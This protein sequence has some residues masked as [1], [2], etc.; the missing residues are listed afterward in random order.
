MSLSYVDLI[1]IIASV[2]SVAG[3][4]PQI[5]KNQKT[6][7]VQDLSAL[8]LLNF[9]VCSLAWVAYGGV[10]GSTYVLLTN[11][12]CLCACGVLLGQKMYFQR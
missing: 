1:G 3:F 2:T 12:A 4:L 9:F 11:V 6:K 5:Y 10:M 8:M 7:S